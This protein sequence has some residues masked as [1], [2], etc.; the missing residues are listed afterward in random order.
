MS[1]P[2]KMWLGGSGPIGKEKATDA[3][4]SFTE[5]PDINLTYVG[6]FFEHG[7]GGC[8]GS[9]YFWDYYE[10]STPDCNFRVDAYTGTMLL[11]SLN[12]SCSNAKI[13]SFTLAKKMV[14]SES[15]ISEVT[16]FTRERYYHFDQR[17]MKLKRWVYPSHDNDYFRFT[18][19][20]ALQSYFE[21][22]LFFRPMDGLLTNYR[23]RDD[24]VEY[25]CAGGKA[26]KIR[27][28]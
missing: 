28:E 14:P 10:F 20:K 21:V 3:I 12:T 19:D 6:R 17:H 2:V 26:E 4:K 5:K 15:T 27:E 1:Y 23:V 18:G 11:A 7:S 22:W 24:V 13:R 25:A 16:N 8:G 9:S